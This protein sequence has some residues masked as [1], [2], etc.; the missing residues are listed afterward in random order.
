MSNMRSTLNYVLV[1]VA[2][3]FVS[4]CGTEDDAGSAPFDG[5]DTVGAPCSVNTD[6]G[7]EN[8][9]CLLDYPGG[10]CGLPCFDRTD[11]PNGAECIPWQDQAVC[12]PGCGGP[13]DCRDGYVCRNTG[14]LDGEESAVCVA[15]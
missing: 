10:Y 12:A 4:A 7:P 8:A 5:L 2:A 14:N 6:C 3:L 9:V 1:A 13:A 15:P 11:C